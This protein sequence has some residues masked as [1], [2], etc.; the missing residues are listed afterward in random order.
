VLER[1]NPHPKSLSS[2]RGTLKVV[3]FFSTKVDLRTFLEKK[4]PII[5]APYPERSTLSKVGIVGLPPILGGLSLAPPRIG[6]LGGPPT[7]IAFSRKPLSASN[8]PS[9]WGEGAGG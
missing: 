7:G 2:G 6:G 4:L 8:S 3:S 9:P 1:L 5:Q